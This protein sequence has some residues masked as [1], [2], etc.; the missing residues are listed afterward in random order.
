MKS[1]TLQLDVGICNETIIFR[2]HGM[3][4]WSEQALSDSKAYSFECFIVIGCDIGQKSNPG[5][6]LLKTEA[7]FAH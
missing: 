5:R 7:Q 6:A 3:V 1:T 2:S 4:S